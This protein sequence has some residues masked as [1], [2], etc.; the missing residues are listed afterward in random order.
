MAE[1][2]NPSDEAF[3][4]FGTEDG[5]NRTCEEVEGKGVEFQGTNL[6]ME[7]YESESNS[8]KLINY[9]HST[10]KWKCPGSF[11]ELD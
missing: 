6:K 4:V 3:V 11:N 5:R 10:L 1:K 8:V 2:L 9:G 7:V